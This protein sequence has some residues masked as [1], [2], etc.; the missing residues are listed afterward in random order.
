MG[1]VVAIGPCANPDVES[2]KFQVSWLYNQ[3]RGAVKAIKGPY[4][5]GKRLL[6]VIPV[7][8]IL[9]ADIK[10]CSDGTLR[11]RDVAVLEEHP[12]LQ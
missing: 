1:H 10:L 2:G 7:A 9:K 4:R 8:T 12:S 3:S 5:K 11:K 6:D